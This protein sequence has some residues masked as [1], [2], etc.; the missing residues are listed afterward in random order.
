MKPNTSD[1]LQSSFIWLILMTPSPQAT[2]GPLPQPSRTRA[3]HIRP[4]KAST[5]NQISRLINS[6]C[7]WLECRFCWSN[8]LPLNIRTRQTVNGTAFSR[9]RQLPHFMITIPSGICFQLVLQ[10]IRLITTLAEHYRGMT[11]SGCH[12]RRTR[13]VWG[14]E[15]C[16][17]Y[18]RFPKWLNWITSSAGL[19]DVDW[20]TCQLI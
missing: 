8:S 18:R 7:C 17:V 5:L 11:K 19:Q 1:L 3:L 16:F 15:Y 10:L 12:T 2:N 6:S 14:R 4:S 9:D 13:L 20:S